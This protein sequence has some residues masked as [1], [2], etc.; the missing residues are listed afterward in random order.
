MEMYRTFLGLSSEGFHNLAYIEWGRHH[1][2]RPAV[3][4]LHGLLRNSHD[5]DALARYLD[6]HGRHVFC[7]DLPGRGNSDWFHS[8]SHYTHEQY[9]ADMTSLIARTNTSQI[10]WI[11]TSLGGIIGMM[12]AALPNTPI[13]RLVLNDI[14]PQIPLHGL[15]R[16]GKYMNDHP[17]FSSKEEAMD[18]YKTIY[19]DFGD[20]T[21][22]E[23]EELTTHSI[24]PLANGKFIAKGDP[25]LMH[26]KTK[27]PFLWELMSHPH[28]ALQGIMYDIDL[29]SIW[30]KITCPVLII[31]GK[32]SDLLLEEHIVRMQ[33]SHPMTEVMEIEDAG[34]APALLRT[35]EHEKIAAWLA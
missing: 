20:L 19:S 24:K 22:A 10:D 15:R 17:E 12:L 1:P 2:E 4:C 25:N 13:H 31:H 11:G 5:F 33:K 3:I 6:H 35:I 30:Q 26:H 29:W 14:G 34:H 8:P 28:K 21:P 7:P 9:I 32:H 16:L 23:W 27:I 18:Y